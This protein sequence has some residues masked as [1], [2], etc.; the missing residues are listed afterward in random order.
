VA[1]YVKPT[2]GDHNRRLAANVMFSVRLDALRA[3]IDDRRRVEQGVLGLGE[4]VFGE[5]VVAAAMST[6]SRR[7]L[8]RSWRDGA[9]EDKTAHDA[10]QT[11][12]LRRKVRQCRSTQS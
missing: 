7:F 8:D 5:E 11:C 4:E 3:G 2:A 1:V 12:R 9:L 10:Y 6:G